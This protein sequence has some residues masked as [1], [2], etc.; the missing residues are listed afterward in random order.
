MKD[1]EGYTKAL[2]AIAKQGVHFILVAISPSSTLTQMTKPVLLGCCEF[3]LTML[4]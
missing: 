1:L 4:R 3:F 2:R